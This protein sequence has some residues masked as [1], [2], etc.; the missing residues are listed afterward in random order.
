MIDLHAAGL[1]VGELAARA[2]ARGL[3]AAAAEAA[4]TSA[5]G[6]AQSIT[7]DEGADA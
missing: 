3:D 4:V 7:M 5:G 2:R 1:K 6:L